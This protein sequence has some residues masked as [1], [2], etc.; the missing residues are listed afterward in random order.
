MVDNIIKKQTISLIVIVVTLILFIFTSLYLLFFEVE[1]YAYKNDKEYEISFCNDRECNNKFY[2]YNNLIGTTR[3]NNK[4]NLR[5][6]NNYDNNILPILEKPYIF[7]I[8]GMEETINIKLRLKEEYIT[9]YDY[10]KYIDNIYI[11]IR[12]KESDLK[13]IRYKDIDGYILENISINSLE[14]IFYVWIW[15]SDSE[16]KNDMY[17]TLEVVVNKK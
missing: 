6:I 1:S 3:E 13:V 7:S 2:N 9:K 4:V 10:K 17:F 15:S 11:G 16:Y 8:K 14:K 12:E 5:K